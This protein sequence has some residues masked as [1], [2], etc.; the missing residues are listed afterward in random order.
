MGGS[1]RL[2]RNPHPINM[3]TIAWSRSARG[4]KGRECS[5]NRRD[6][7]GVSQFPS[8]TP[9]RRNTFDTPN[10]CG[11]FGTQ[12]TSIS[13]LVR[14]TADGSEPQIDGRGSVLELLKVDSIAE[15]HS[16]VKR[17]PRL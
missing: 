14:D 17:E 11:E 2:S 4:V 12:Q 15:N 7:S 1:V 16:A 6:C 10:A 5:S 9:R 8:R 13:S 3:A